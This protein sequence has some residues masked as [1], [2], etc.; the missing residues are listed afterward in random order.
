MPA[1]AAAAPGAIVRRGGVGP[2]GLVPMTP[3]GPAGQ[4]PGNGQPAAPKPAGD[5]DIKSMM[6]PALLILGAYL[7]SRGGGLGGIF[8]GAKEEEEDERPRGRFRLTAAEIRQIEAEREEEDADA[9]DAEYSE[10]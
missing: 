6:W 3:I 7:I 9:L 2:A 4:Q 5:F 8:G 1:A 10:P